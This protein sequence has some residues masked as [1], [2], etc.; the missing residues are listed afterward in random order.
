MELIALFAHQHSAQQC[1]VLGGKPAVRR[2]VVAKVAVAPGANLELETGV[3]RAGVEQEGVELIQRLH[4]IA[5]NSLRHGV[6]DGEVVVQELAI[7][8]GH[9]AFGI[10]GLRSVQSRRHARIVR[11]ERGFGHNGEQIAPVVAAGLPVEPRR[12]V[13]AVRRGLRVE[14]LEERLVKAVILGL[15]FLRE[16]G[17]AGFCG[18]LDGQAQAVERKKVVAGEMA[19][20]VLVVAHIARRDNVQRVGGPRL[21]QPVDGAIDLR[22]RPLGKG[23]V[24]RDAV[25]LRVAPHGLAP[26]VVLLRLRKKVAVGLLRFGEEVEAFARDLRVAGHVVTVHNVGAVAE[27]KGVVVQLVDGLDKV[28]ADAIDGDEVVDEAGRKSV[29]GFRFWQLDLHSGREN[30]VPVRDDLRLGGVKSNLIEV[31]ED[32]RVGGGNDR[33]L[34]IQRALSAGRQQG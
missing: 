6:F 32:L 28:G 17:V 29:D 4:L 2:E 3:G 15:P 25:V 7:G 8:V 22:Q 24:M 31:R 1:A 20:N 13:P 10:L 16:I 21:V 11:I 18:H 14:N 23:L 12:K 33:H 5:A 26:A 27:I 19:G 30:L 9:N 34:E